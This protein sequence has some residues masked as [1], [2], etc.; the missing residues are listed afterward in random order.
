[1]KILESKRVKIKNVGNF[2]NDLVGRS[3][4]HEGE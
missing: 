4:Q 1:M 3:N 2:I